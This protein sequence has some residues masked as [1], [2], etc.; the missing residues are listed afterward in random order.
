M[1]EPSAVEWAIR[2]LRRYADFAG[3]APRAEYWWFYLAYVV[4]GFAIDLL[5]TVLGLD[6]YFGLAFTVAL[7]VPLLAATFRR[8]HDTNRSGWWILPMLL[9]LPLAAV[10]WAPAIAFA[11]TWTEVP[12]SAAICSLLFA[13]Y[14]LLVL[15]FTIQPG[16]RGSN[17]FG[18]D[19]YA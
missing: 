2:P 19:P 3:R 11:E 17:A 10:Y 5:E 4:I 18:E 7:F 15:V 9:L 6:G 16:T 1:S 14:L 12:L 13:A 8:L